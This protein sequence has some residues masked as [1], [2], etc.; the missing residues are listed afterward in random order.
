MC[1]VNKLL[2]H[3][4]IA[5]I[6]S[7]IRQLWVIG[8]DF[9]RN[10]YYDSMA[11]V[12]E[13]SSYV[14][15]NFELKDFFGTPSMGDSTL[16]RILNAIIYA[17]NEYEHFPTIIAVI[18][19]DDLIRKITYE[20][21]D[22]ADV[23]KAELIWLM[24]NINRAIDAKKEYCPPKAKLPNEP[25]VVWL[26]PPENV[27]FN[28]NQ[29]RKIFTRVL[30]KAAFCFDNTS[31]LSFKQIWSADDTTVFLKEPDRYTVVGKKKFWEAADRTLRFCHTINFK[32][33]QK[34]N[35]KPDR[36]DD[37]K[38]NESPKRRPKTKQ[39]AKRKPYFNRNEKI[40]WRPNVSG[41][42]PKRKY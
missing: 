8:D 5:E 41:N 4:L 10:T 38:N 6:P 39:E 35:R 18:L 36:E 13:S 22:L 23:Y 42:Y 7:G 27:N 14:K 17:L 16:R 33:L 32:T 1:L 12:P 15:S 31:V 28:N 9:A 29:K 24:K 37:V 3:F 25:H 30:Q 21:D 40:R 19:D 34:R 20:G 2:N 11:T 26:A